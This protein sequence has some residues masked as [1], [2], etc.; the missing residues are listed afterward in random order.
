MIPS[1]KQATKS[2]ARDNCP[3]PGKG[4]DRI[5]QHLPVMQSPATNGEMRR[6]FRVAGRAP[7]AVPRFPNIYR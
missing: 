3:R 6:A 2:T 7:G 4:G 5:S 1:S